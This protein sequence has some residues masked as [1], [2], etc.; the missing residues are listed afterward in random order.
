MLQLEGRVI[1]RTCYMVFLLYIYATIR[2]T[3]Y[4]LQLEGRVIR[5]LYIYIYIYI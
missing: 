1:R 5:C 3:C 4:M 2:R